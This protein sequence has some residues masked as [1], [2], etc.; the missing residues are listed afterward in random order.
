MSLT[1]AALIMSFYLITTSVVT[2]LLIPARELAPGGSANG[3]ALAGRDA[4]L[5]LAAESLAFAHA[6]EPLSRHAVEM[7]AATGELRSVEMPRLFETFRTLPQPRLFAS[8]ALGEGGWLK[9][10]RL[11]GYAPPGPRRPEGL[12]QALF[13]HHEAWG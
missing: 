3:R 2:T 5:W 11:A 6:G 9:A 8:D 4:A 1:L 10:L 12:Q 7:E 13:A